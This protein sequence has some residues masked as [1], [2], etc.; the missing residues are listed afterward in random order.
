MK[1]IIYRTEGGDLAVVMPASNT[2]LSLEEIIKKDVPSESPRDVIDSTQL[3]ADRFFPNGVDI[4][5]R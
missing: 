3:P 2:K 5:L 4:Q 1:R